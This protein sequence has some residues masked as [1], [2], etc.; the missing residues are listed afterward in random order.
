MGAGP[1][2]MGSDMASPVP[3]P[4][5]GSV[6]KMKGLPF[7]ACSEDVLKFYGG[8]SIKA[9]CIYL[10]RHPDGRPSGEAFVVFES[11]DEAQRA[12]QKDRET[13]G[14]KFGDR[15]VR[16]YPTLESDVADMQQAVHVQNMVAQGH[17]HMHMDSV[18]KM[19]SLP[20]DATQLDIIQFFEAYRL[21]PNGVQLVVRSDNKPTGEAFVDFENYEEAARAMREKDHKVFNEKFGDRYVRLIQ[22]SRKEMQATLALRFGGEGI[23]KVKGIPFKAGAGDVRKFFNGYKIKPEG[24]SFIMHADGR[25]TGMAFIEFE[26][27]QEAVRAMEKDRAKFGPEY[28]DRFCMLQ[29]VGRHEM[30]KVQLQHESESNHKIMSGLNG[31]PGLGGMGG[32]LNA[33]GMSGISGINAAALALQAL[34]AANPA[35]LMSQNPWLASHM[36]Q[37]LGGMAG[38]MAGGH[39]G[40]GQLGQLPATGPM[41]MPPV[42]HAQLA[43]AQQ[44][45]QQF[46]GGGMSGLTSA[47]N[48]LGLQASPPP[49]QGAPGAAEGAAG[50]PAAARPTT[51]PPAH[52]AA[53]LSAGLGAGGEQGYATM[54][55]VAAIVEAAERAAQRW[56]VTYTHFHTP[57]VVADALA[58]LAGRGDVAGVPWGGY[59]QAERVRLALGRDEALAGA[60]EDPAGQL[61]GAVAALEVRGN[62]MFDPAGHR[63]FLG[64]ILG[65]GVVRDRVGD[66]LV[67]GESGAQILVDPELVEHF[68][69][70]LTQVRTVPVETRGVPLAQLR[71]PPPRREEVHSTEASLRL[72]AVASAGFRMSRGKMADLIK[73]GD[74]RLN[75]RPAAKASVEV[76]VG[77]VVA[78][79]GKGRLEVISIA[80]TK[81]DRFAVHMVRST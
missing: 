58:A 75:Y 11:P 59:A 74:V 65:T 23:L 54:K 2:P 49:G 40:L 30:D 64:A 18:V 26:T 55:D 69:A 50:C 24:V 16:V 32:G 21:K 27:P 31:V 10:K 14:E 46:N 52:M 12:C 73:A 63:D 42:D 60:A 36:H 8:F 53:A 68:E 72:D 71:V 66:I 22:V 57:P 34:A 78:C 25:P 4:L 43:A 28:G 1:E 61:P 47:L 9:S 81:K 45:G 48:G 51:C 5:D 3:L 15:Y 41:A 7:K 33:A 62:F 19:K 35:L 13:F 6:V 38:P 37:M 44:L 56:E 17:S 70:A 67:Q 80:T 76:K 79:A 77:D 39:P 20:F 29:L